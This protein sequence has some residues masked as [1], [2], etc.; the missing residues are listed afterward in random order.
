MFFLNLYIY[1]YIYICISKAKTILLPN[2]QRL[3]LSLSLSLATFWQTPGLKQQLKMIPPWMFHVCWF[4][5]DFKKR[6]V[7]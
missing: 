3:S 6:G 1:N 7:L 5:F 2:V 4:G